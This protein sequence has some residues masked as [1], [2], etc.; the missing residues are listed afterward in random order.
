MVV[1]NHKDEGLG[2]EVV[3]K[4]GEG[5]INPATVLRS[6]HQIAKTTSVGMT[7]SNIYSWHHFEKTHS[8]LVSSSVKCR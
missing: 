3:L 2:K 1:D 4:T 7:D 5:N 6:T 8:L